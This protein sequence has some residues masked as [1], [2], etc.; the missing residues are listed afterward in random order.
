MD[1]EY[2]K[3]IYKKYFNVLHAYSLHIV[4]KAEVAEDIVQ[5][6]FLECWDRRASIDVVA[7]LKPY[8]Y[9]LTRRKSIDF[10]RKSE[11]KNLLFSEVETHL[12]QL[13]FETLALDERIDMREIGQII[14]ET[15]LLLPPKCKEVF[16][17]SRENG[18]KNRQIAETL[19]L[20]IKTV[21]KHITRA[22]KQI[23]SALEERGHLPIVIF[24]FLFLH[25]P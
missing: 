8:L 16:L 23:R 1:S 7:S 21:E 11:T 12:D 9:T 4:S 24:F 22:I 20:S 13:F 5:E 19:D 6:V 15:I 10:L 3:I 2:F 25:K 14:E 18:M 17:L